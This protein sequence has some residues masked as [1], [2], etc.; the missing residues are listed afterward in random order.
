MADAVAAEVSEGIAGGIAKG[1]MDPSRYGIRHAESRT[2]DV[3]P[4]RSAGKGYC[5]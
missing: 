1:I 4:A 2:V 5:D 3:L